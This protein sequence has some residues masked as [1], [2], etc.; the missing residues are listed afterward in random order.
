MPEASTT[1]V[2]LE[3]DFAILLVLHKCRV[4]KVKDDESIFTSPHVVYDLLSKL[5]ARMSSG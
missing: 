2:Y 3:A 4:A 1:G 5:E